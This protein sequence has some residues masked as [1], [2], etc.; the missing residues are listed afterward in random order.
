MP[1]MPRR[2]ELDADGLYHLRGQVSGPAG[3]YPLQV[4]VN[5]EKLIEIIRHFCLLFCCQVVAL[6][7]MGN[8]Y[9][10][11]L[12]FAPFRKLV[13]EELWA[14]AE[15]FYQNPVYQPYLKWK[16]QDWERFNRRLFDVSE[17]M[18]NIQS[19]FARWFNDQYD[20]KGR[21]WASRF[22]SCESDNLQ[23]T[24]LYVELNA[25]RAH[26]VQLPE[27]W[28]YSS[29]WLRK[30]GQDDW[31]MSLQQLLGEPDDS[32]LDREQAE[33]LYWTRLYWRGTQ[34]SKENDGLIP[35]EL[36]ERMEQ[37]AFGRGCYLQPRPAFSRG[38]IVGTLETVKRGLEKMKA[39]GFCKR[40]KNPVPL[41]IGNLFALREQRRNYV[42]I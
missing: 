36:A 18:R 37:E 24:A 39:K 2:I 32:P 14:V 31:L 15:R 11:V 26:L 5:A 42:P 10:L 8:H 41:G 12:L 33:K 19:G 3:Y 9:H 27:Q 7:I 16:D 25:L 1:R 34:A 17:L 35:V 38:L 13:F 4:P 28:R 21:F 22:R 20:R 30:Q 40:R 23:E 29:A 6:E